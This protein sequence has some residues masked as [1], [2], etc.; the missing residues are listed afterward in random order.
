MMLCVFYC[1]REP[2]HWK[3]LENPRGTEQ[4]SNAALLFT[5]KPN[6]IRLHS[7]VGPTE[8]CLYS[9]ECTWLSGQETNFNKNE[10]TATQ[11]EGNFIE[12]VVLLN[13]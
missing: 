6:F 2:R 4:Y 8:R 13:G 5:L 11:R 7:A 3:H 1:M 10:E 12:G 9:V